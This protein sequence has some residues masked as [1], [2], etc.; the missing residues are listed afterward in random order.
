MG[1]NWL[2]PQPTA[3]SAMATRI[4]GFV[5]RGCIATEI[6]GFVTRGCMS[7]SERATALR[8]L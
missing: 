2:A 5:V 3:N 7:V 6:Q 1:E 8:G 4:Q